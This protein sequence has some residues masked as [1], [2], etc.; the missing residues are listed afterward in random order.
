MTRDNPCEPLLLHLGADLRRQIHVTEAAAERH[1][2]L[3]G[4]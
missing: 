3:K 4:G 1:A 2:F